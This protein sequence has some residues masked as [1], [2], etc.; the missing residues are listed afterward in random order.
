METGS[1]ELQKGRLALESRSQ[2]A[3]LGPQPTVKSRFA[4][5]LSV[6]FPWPILSSPFPCVTSALGTHFKGQNQYVTRKECWARS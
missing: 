3:I 5:I 6:F 4:K 1:A 2:R